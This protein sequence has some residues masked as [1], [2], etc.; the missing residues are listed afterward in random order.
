MTREEF[1][2]WYAGTEADDGSTLFAVYEGVNEWVAGEVYVEPA[3]NGVYIEA[4]DK[5]PYD[6][7]RALK[8]WQLFFT[9]EEAEEYLNDGDFNL[10]YGNPWED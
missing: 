8:Y 1:K 10:D 3:H 6:S 7:T 2:K 4:I 5:N 9:R